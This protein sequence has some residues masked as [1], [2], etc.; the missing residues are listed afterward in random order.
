MVVPF[1]H[2]HPGVKRG[3]LSHG[4]TFALGYPGHIRPVNI[5]RVIAAPEVDQFAFV[6]LDTEYAGYEYGHQLFIL[7]FLLCIVFHFDESFWLCKLSPREK[8]RS[9]TKEE[10]EYR[11]TK[12]T[13]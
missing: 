4:F 8:A 9:V 2:H 7:A 6:L 13:Q 3:Y 1:Q 11:N 5:L 12:T 10:L